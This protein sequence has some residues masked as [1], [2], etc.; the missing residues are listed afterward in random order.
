MASVLTR[1]EAEQRSA[2]LEVPEVEV[3]LDLAEADFGTAST[4]HLRLREAG[5]FAVN[6]AGSRLDA[7]VVDGAPVDPEW[8]EGRILLD[9]PRGDHAVEV[10]GRADYRGD[11]EGMH[12]HVDRDGSV[13]L[14]AMSFL[15][16]AP[17]WFACIDQPDIKSRYRLVVTAPQEWR[18]VGNAPMHV[19]DAADVSEARR[20]WRSDTTPPLPSYLITLVA[21]AYVCH[22]GGSI[23][24]PGKPGERIG[25]RLFARA[26]L[27]EQLAE[28]GDDIL[29]VTRAAMV[30]Y[31][32][33]FGQPYAFGDYDQVFVPDFNAGAME[34][35]GCV[36][37]QDRLL[38]RGAVTWA[39]VAARVGTICHEMA[40]M[41]F[42][43]LVTMRWWDELWL[44]EAFAEYSSME[45]AST[46]TDHQPWLEFAVGRRDNATVADRAPSTH[47]VAGS[48]APDTRAALSN[49]DAISYSKGAAVLRQLATRLGD[50]EFQAGLRRY[51]EAHAFGNA[52]LADLLEVWPGDHDGFAKAWLQV[53]GMDELVAAEVPGG[54]EVSCLPVAE[55]VRDHAVQVVGIGADGTE[56]VRR[57]VVVAPGEPVVVP[58]PDQVLLWL[59][60]AGLESWA[61]M[62]APLPDHAPP[63]S[64]I[65][66][67]QVR[68]AALAQLR[69]GV[70]LGRIDPTLALVAVLEAMS[71][72]PL[73]PLFRGELNFVI[74]D[75][76][77][78]FAAPAL[79]TERVAQVA[80]A[81]AP[82]LAASEP[83]SDH[84]L[85][86][87]RG[88]LRVSDDIDWLTGLL[89]GDVQLPGRKL[90]QSLRWK[91]VQRLA[92]LGAPDDL[93]A[94]ESRLDPSSEGDAEAALA[95]ALQPD[96]DRKRLLLD[97]LASDTPR[98]G[99]EL[100]M[101]AGGLFRADQYALVE[102]L[103]P[104][105]FEILAALPDHHSGWLMNRI[106]TA[107]FPGEMTSEE[108]LAA[109]RELAARPKLD[110]GLRRVVIDGI[111][112]LEQAM[113][114][115]QAYS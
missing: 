69:D 51:F 40:H 54:A 38:F 32:E 18:V 85:T 56:V 107:L 3:M 25:L 19:D 7:V 42:G 1:A 26:S 115:Q 72:E 74:H 20:R 77:G 16:N 8:D 73:E 21:G 31:H 61:T 34:T 70:R 86:A 57:Q 63:I 2:L 89:S 84:Q 48:E 112:T 98:R 58:A 14:Y 39:E 78:A 47:P 5:E 66:D 114:S 30:E 41:W 113:A 27:A 46:V 91:A 23:E 60:D 12:R 13:Y 90:D 28:Q 109:A 4:I 94:V 44:N 88:L 95:L 49:F 9:L 99:A 62:S 111:H 105:C 67:P 75:L 10:R 96:L 79:R 71:T 92:S 83:G 64:A 101:V 87:A 97:S 15:D 37:F 29:E 35:P 104:R 100:V 80:A 50:E 24:H 103:V 59:P 81:L 45:V 76:A 52:T 6:F 22:D 110:S 17:S 65:A 82:M 55:P 43:D 53:A 108:T 36:L 106:A 33:R 68:A 102:P 93:I 11:A